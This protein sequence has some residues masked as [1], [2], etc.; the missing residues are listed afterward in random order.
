MSRGREEGRLA[1]K[2]TKSTKEPKHLFLCFLC[3]LW[4]I[5]FGSRNHIECKCKRMDLVI[6]PELGPC[7][8]APWFRHQTFESD[9]RAAAQFL[10]I[11]SRC[12]S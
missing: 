9:I 7:A 4:L 1:T 11:R 3:L 2:G 5:L 12:E 6:A 8:V 10:E